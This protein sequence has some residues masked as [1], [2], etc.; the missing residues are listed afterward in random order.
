MLL[1]TDM[2]VDE[3]Y[4][5]YLPYMGIGLMMVPDL[6]IWNANITGKSG[7]NYLLFLGLALFIYIIQIKT[8]QRLPADMLLTQFGPFVANFITLLARLPLLFF[9]PV[10]ILVAAGFVFNEVFVHW[11]PNFGFAGLLLLLV[12]LL[13]VF[14]KF[15]LEA[16]ILT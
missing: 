3:N 10:S 13:Q 14:V 1:L 7:I 8:I 11:F 15:H 6:F 12:I 5:K 9:L 2:R 16:T 4:I